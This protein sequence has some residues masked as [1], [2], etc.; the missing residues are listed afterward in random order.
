MSRS[1]AVRIAI[2]YGPNNLPGA[3]IQAVGAT[4]PCYLQSE[5]GLENVVF[6]TVHHPEGRMVQIHVS[7]LVRALEGGSGSLAQGGAR[8]ELPGGR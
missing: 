3:F 5:R 6:P 8:I 1:E 2:V 7:W 4:D